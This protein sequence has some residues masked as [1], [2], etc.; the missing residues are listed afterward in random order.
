ML[1][2][3][4]L[5]KFPGVFFFSSNKEKRNKQV[6]TKVIEIHPLGTMNI[7]GSEVMNPT[8]VGLFQSVTK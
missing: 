2:W 8:V 6:N 5:R 1:A 7:W 4:M 3:L